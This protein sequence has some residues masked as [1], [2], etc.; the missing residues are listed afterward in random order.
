MYFVH[1]RLPNHRREHC[2]LN[3]TPIANHACKLG[4]ISFCHFGVA[5]WVTDPNCRCVL[6]RKTNEPS[7]GVVV[8]CSGFTRCWSTVFKRC[9][10]CCSTLN[11]PTHDIGRQICRFSR[12]SLLNSWTLILIQHRPSCIFNSLDHVWLNVHTRVRKSLRACS[13][14]HRT[15]FVRTS[16]KTGVRLNR[17][18]L[19]T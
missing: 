8:L 19:F 6:R 4:H 18:C 3:A 7:I 16:C 5:L 17:E 11:N 15:Q 1:I 9:A 10:T 12:Q 14:I 13:H 2:T